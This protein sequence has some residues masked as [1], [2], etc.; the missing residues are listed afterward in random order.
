MLGVPATKA[1]S[2]DTGRGG[3]E[4]S[5]YGGLIDVEALLHTTTGVSP[6]PT[7]SS[8]AVDT[9][10]GG[11]GHYTNLTGDHS[12]SGTSSTGRGPARKSHR[13][14]ASP[15][16]AHNGGG[17]GDLPT[18]HSSAS[19]TPRHAGYMA[20]TAPDA[21]GAHD[22]DGC[23]GL[24]NGT[25][26][27]GGRKPMQN[28]DVLH[29]PAI[30]TQ[31]QQRKRANDAF[32]TP[33]ARTT[34]SAH[35]PSSHTG[36]LAGSTARVATGAKS[37]TSAGNLK[38]L[39]HN[40]NDGNGAASNGHFSNGSAAVPG[41]HRPPYHAP[42]LSPLATRGRHGNGTGAAGD[43]L[44]GSS[45]VDAGLRGAGAGQRRTTD[46]PVKRGESVGICE[47]GGG[48]MGGTSSTGMAHSTTDAP[49]TTTA[50]TGGGG[51]V[52]TFK[53]NG[54]V[55]EEARRLNQNAVLL[56]EDATS[57]ASEQRRTTGE[58]SPRNGRQGGGAAAD[59][60][61]AF[62]RERIRERAGAPAAAPAA[63]A[64][65]AAT[66]ERGDRD[67][68][69]AGT[70]TRVNTSPATVPAKT[71][72]WTGDYE[73][74]SCFDVEPVDFSVAPMPKVGPS[75][76]PQATGLRS[77]STMAG[78]GDNGVTSPADSAITPLRKVFTRPQKP[79]AVA[80]LT[81]CP[82]PPVPLTH[83]PGSS[84]A[85]TTT[86]PSRTSTAA[87][88]AAAAATKL[89]PTRAD[90]PP[91]TP[92]TPPASHRRVMNAVDTS[93]HTHVTAVSSAGDDTTPNSGTGQT[94][95]RGGSSTGLPYTDERRAA[96]EAW[97]DLPVLAITIRGQALTPTQRARETA[98]T[99]ARPA[100]AQQMC[101]PVNGQG[102]Q[103]VAGEPYE[104]N[105]DVHNVVVQLRHRNRPL[106]MN[107]PPRLPL[108]ADMRPRMRRQRTPRSFYG[109]RMPHVGDAWFKDALDD[110]RM[111]ASPDIDAMERHEEEEFIRGGGDPATRRNRY[112]QANNAHGQQQQ[113]QQQQQ[114][115]PVHSGGGGA[116]GDNIDAINRN[117]VPLEQPAS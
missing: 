2:G 9:D 30:G 38:S 17:G 37:V 69:A 107:Y 102:R 45:S 61:T 117:A 4:Y 29:L 110:A 65:T 12:Y 33:R 48:G 74:A 51:G 25:S 81:P 67:G 93:Q 99:R 56:G 114:R 11:Y 35:D 85:A 54:W 46:A 55:R 79:A 10:A 57:P 58:S 90:K 103:E 22:D 68:V 86:S 75:S 84:T 26:R 52:G 21:G 20:G 32:P 47:D 91:A 87:A 59:A 95:P 70:R 41:L 27:T 111:V 44:T 80:T 98:R 73:M 78:R 116:G 53:T 63:A 31:Q 49:T 62:P 42:P 36:T 104:M 77:T 108:D 112:G 18:P 71:H 3:Y 106:V 72:V 105:Y 60:A 97:A 115:P 5:D 96:L 50:T 64:A 43:S 23:I 83:P 7:L 1:T 24:A 28:E 113:Q 88:A 40:T 8:T 76:R 101:V 92:H 100:N 34:A 15:A 14:S 94:P 6:T 82:A 19:A 39:Q 109:N 13:A 89:A 66:A 16:R